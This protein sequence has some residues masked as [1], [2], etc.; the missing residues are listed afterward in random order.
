MAEKLIENDKTEF[1]SIL[2]D[3]LERV[4]VS[5]LNSKTGGDIFIGVADNG[6]IVGVKDPDK[7]QLAISDRIKNN[8]LPTCMGLFDVF[9]E[10]HHGRIIIHII[11]SSGTEKPYYIKS[12]GMSPAGCYMRVGS[13]VQQMN[14][15][16]ID[17]LY[18]SRTRNSL[19]NIVSPRY[20][21]HSFAQLKIYYEERG[22]QVNDAFLQNLDLYT[23]DGKYNYVAYLLADVN[24]VSIKVARYAGADKC[25]LIE[26]EDYGYCS[27]IKATERVLDKLEVEN[28][29]FTKIT[30]AAKRSERR[31]IDRLALREAFINAI[32]HN[33]YSRD[34]SPVVEIFSN[35]L[36]ITS[37]GGLVEGL[38]DEDFFSGRSMPRNR[39]LMRVFRDLEF[40]EHLG[41][42]MN[43]ILKVYD[44]GIFKI[45]DNFLET[46]F[47]FDEDYLDDTEQVTVQVTIQ[48]NHSDN[49]A[50]NEKN[51]VTPVQ[52]TVQV[53]IQVTV[54]VENMVKI[55]KGI[56]SGVEMMKLLKLNNRAHFHL[57]YLQPAIKEGLV[58]MTIPD[59]PK[60]RFQK[61]KLTEKGMKLHNKLLASGKKGKD[62]GTD[63]NQVSEP[64]QKYNT[65]QVT[66]HDT[67]HVTEHVTVQVNGKDNKQSADNEA[68]K[69]IIN[70]TVHVKKNNTVHDTVQVTVHVTVQVESLVKVLDGELS[71]PEMMN[72]LGLKNRPHFKLEYLQPA[73]DMGAI[74]TTMPGKINNSLQKFR[75]TL[76][77]REIKKQLG[78][79]KYE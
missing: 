46:V 24:S 29:T 35:H 65:E 21:P 4:V 62:Y 22:F 63:I 60:S 44:K 10:D 33:D 28:K 77:G 68:E 42:G 13:G 43:R 45:T 61:Y 37:Y 67:V 59:K 71:I 36:S 52:D 76:K 16:M 31:M 26:N 70:N 8:I 51:T 32:V 72:K 12:F 57:D 9:S 34:V 79:L 49:E 39:E 64:E 73:L 7:V 69:N 66:V 47:P 19:R 48:D 41:S 17:C 23:A 18:G 58:E 30:G 5:F 14:N 11:V 40:V 27:L 25:D 2:N 56:M 38:S 55:L 78:G 3:K 20:A 74:E 15:A 54:Q 53:T 6:S 75:L 50:D 1:K